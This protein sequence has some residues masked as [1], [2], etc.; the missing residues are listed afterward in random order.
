MM[1]GGNGPRLDGGSIALDRIGCTQN[2]R[3]GGFTTGT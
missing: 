2:A 3:F 1:T